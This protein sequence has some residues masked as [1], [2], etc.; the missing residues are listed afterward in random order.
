M[1][2]AQATAE[3]EDGLF[4]GGFLGEEVEPKVRRGDRQ[5]DGRST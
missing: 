4:L 3:L 5:P 2:A 1:V